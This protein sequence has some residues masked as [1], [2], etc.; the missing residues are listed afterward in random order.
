MHTYIIPYYHWL[1]KN[2][3]KKS[4]GNGGQCAWEWRSLATSI[5]FNSAKMQKTRKL[6]KSVCSKLIL[7]WFTGWMWNNRMFYL[8]CAVLYWCMVVL[9]FWGRNVLTGTLVS[10]H[11][12]LETFQEKLYS[13]KY[14]RRKK[15]S[16]WGSSY[17][18]SS[19]AWTTCLHAYNV[20]P[21]VFSVH[22]NW[23]LVDVGKIL[24][25]DLRGLFKCA[26]SELVSN[27]YRLQIRL[28]LLFMKINWFCNSV[29]SNHE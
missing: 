25:M 13:L 20:F 10:R 4:N 3:Y 21:H 15:T 19:L 17:E 28:R 22:C 16:C 2:N 11:L 24:R 5:L 27:R 1:S 26:F 12:M 29:F 8:Q 6:K 9:G 14:L 7:K 23:R 18:F